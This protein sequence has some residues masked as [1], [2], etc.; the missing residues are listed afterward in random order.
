[1]SSCEAPDNTCMLVVAT[2][3]LDYDVRNMEKNEYHISILGV[4]FPLFVCMGTH[5]AVLPPQQDYLMGGTEQNHV[6]FLLN[7]FLQI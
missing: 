3:V 7:K 1:M 6:K 5:A 2:H 4:E